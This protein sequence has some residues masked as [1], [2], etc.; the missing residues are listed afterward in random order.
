VR[1]SNSFSTE[2]AE[3]GKAMC[4]LATKKQPIPLTLVRNP[5][6]AGFYRKMVAMTEVAKARALAGIGSEVRPD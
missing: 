4:E 2:E 1:H 3:V 6:F 5:A